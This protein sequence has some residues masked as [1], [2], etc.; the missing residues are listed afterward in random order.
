MNL[1]ATTC[2]FFVISFHSALS[3]ESVKVF[4]AKM[5]PRNRPLIILSGVDGWIFKPGNDSS[6][7]NVQA[8]TSDWRILKPTELTAKAVSYT[9]L[10]AHETPEHLVCRLLLE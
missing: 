7:A 5:F 10:R 9:H 6:W 8:N 2:L 4:S 3:Q 1:I